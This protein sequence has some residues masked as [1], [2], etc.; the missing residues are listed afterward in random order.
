[1]INKVEGDTSTSAGN[2]KIF[3]KRDLPPIM[4]VI[5]YHAANPQPQCGVNKNTKK[6]YIKLK[7]SMLDSQIFLQVNLF[8]FLCLYC[9]FILVGLKN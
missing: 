7:Y 5:L 8:A 6:N 2:A 1:M 9:Y 3:N 4:L